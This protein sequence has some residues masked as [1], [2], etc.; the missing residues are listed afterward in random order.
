MLM[1][2]DVENGKIR[3]RNNN[4]NNNNRQMHYVEIQIIQNQCNEIP[5]KPFK[6]SRI[7][8]NHVMD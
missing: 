2:E 7:N 6:R 8:V 5:R 4:N 3:G 1:V